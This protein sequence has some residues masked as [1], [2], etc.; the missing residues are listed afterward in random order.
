MTT[1]LKGKLLFNMLGKPLLSEWLD[2]TFDKTRIPVSS[3]GDL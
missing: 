1:W 2:G 3:D